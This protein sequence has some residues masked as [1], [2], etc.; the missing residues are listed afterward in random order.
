M[1]IVRGKAGWDPVNANLMVTV[2]C[3]IC[4]VLAKRPI[5]KR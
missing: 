4:F 3:C 5:S 1:K 2:D